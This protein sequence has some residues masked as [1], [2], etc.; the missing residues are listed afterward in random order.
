QKAGFTPY[1][2]LEFTIGNLAGMFFLDNYIIKVY[3]MDEMKF[4]HDIPIDWSEFLAFNLTDLLL[5][6]LQIHFPLDKD[7]ADIIAIILKDEEISRSKIIETI[8][9]DYGLWKD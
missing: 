4:N 2:H 1:Y 5:S 6:K 9:N 7:I 8:S 3:Y